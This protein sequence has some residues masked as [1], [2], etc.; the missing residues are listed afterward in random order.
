MTTDEKNDK[1]LIEGIL[2]H[3]LGR[4]RFA[5][6]T[7]ALAGTAAAAGT[8][9]Q[10]TKVR[11]VNDPGIPDA[12]E[13]ASGVDVRYSVCL[14][15][16]APDKG[17]AAQD[18]PGVQT[19]LELTSTGSGVYAD[20]TD[21][22][23][24]S[25][26]VQKAGGVIHWNRVHDLPDHAFF[27]HQW[28]VKAGVACQTCHG[29]IETMEV[30]QQVAP[31]TMGWC[32]SCHR[33]DNY[34]GGPGYDGSPESFTVGTGDYV[35]VRQRIRPDD[36]VLYH[37]RPTAGVHAHDHDQPTQTVEGPGEE[38]Q[39]LRGIFAEGRDDQLYNRDY[40]TQAQL[41]KLRELFARYRDQDGRSTLPRWRIPDL[42]EVHA[43]FYHHR[44]EGQGE[45]SFLEDVKAMGTYQNAPTQCSTCHQ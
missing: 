36:V 2:D 32:L 31:L 5:K 17:A 43:Q 28:H 33:D 44:G 45:E 16:H 13:T 30:V 37:D 26:G 27:S 4:R 23:G 7:G 20:D 3:P 11:A 25:D 12:P 42:P 22:D 6:V 41:E 21:A 34:V 14:G 29:P 15:C 39:R 10:P 9:L 18:R 19:L 8:L 38:Q 1:G 24:Y 40:T 35:V